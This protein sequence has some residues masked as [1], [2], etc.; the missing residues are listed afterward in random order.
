[1][2]LQLLA[3]A[4]LLKTVRLRVFL[5]SRAEN[6]IRHGFSQ[7]PRSEYQDFVL[8]GVSPAIIEL[9]I[10]IFLEHNLKMIR[11]E[12]HL[13]SDWPGEQDLRRLVEHANG[14]FIWAAT[15]CRFIREGRRFVAD[16]LSILLKD[17]SSVSDSVGD[18]S[19]DD[20]STDGSPTDD[21]TIA[22]EKHLNKIYITVLKN[23]ARNYKRQER[24]KWY[25]LLRE[26]TGAIILLFS[27]LSAFPL[28]AL[29]DVRGEDII[30]TLDDLHSILEI[31]QD[32]ARPIRLH[33]PS[34]R[35]FFIDKKRCVDSNLWV[36][37]K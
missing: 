10:F 11:Q 18:S 31:P 25:K 19:M 6:P 3:E 33:H 2:I 24:K 17:D 37:E 29:L 30:R 27:P 7:I 34:F 32:Q 4:R 13:A 21:A 12:F 14:L 36:D 9:D 26:T 8:H 20:S 35:D 1:M 16:R 5:I 22:P 28:A 15:A 23:S